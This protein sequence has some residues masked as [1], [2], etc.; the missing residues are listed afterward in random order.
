MIPK[1]FLN[2][3]CMKTLKLENLRWYTAIIYNDTMFLNFYQ[4]LIMVTEMLPYIYF[5]EYIR[6]NIGRNSRKSML[7]LIL[8][9]D[10]MVLCL[11]AT[12]AF[13]FNTMRQALFYWITLWIFFC[14]I[15]KF[16]PTNIFGNFLF[17]SP[18][19]I[20]TDCNIKNP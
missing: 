11:A 12:H 6:K 18:S 16:L 9:H 3:S 7:A 14:F 10:K 19:F 2:W 4:F 8:G 20:N 5:K 15:C 17:D 13:I 1:F